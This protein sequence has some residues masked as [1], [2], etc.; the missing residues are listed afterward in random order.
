MAKKR[1]KKA[2]A[3]P[4]FQARLAQIKKA[5]VSYEY[6]IPYLAGYSKDGSRLYLDRT[7][8]KKAPCAHQD[9]DDILEHEDWEKTSIDVWHLPYLPAHEIAIQA[10][11]ALLMRE[12]RSPSAYNERLKPWIERDELEP[13]TAKLPP[14]LDMTPY[15]GSKWDK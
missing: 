14:D 4:A 8:W 6:D 1:Y 12:G 3:D 13:A 2:L 11:N 10:E 9:R 7:F 5:T 15:K